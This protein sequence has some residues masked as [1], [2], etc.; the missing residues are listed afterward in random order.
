MLARTGSDKIVTSVSRRFAF[1]ARNRWFLGTVVAPTLLSAGYFGLIASDVYVSEARFV[2]RSAGQKSVQMPSIS[3]LLQSSGTSDTKD[4]TNEVLD[5]IKSR[6]ALE[7]LQRGVHIR[8]RYGS[9]QADV[10]S[11]YPGL[12]RVDAFENLYRYYLRMIDARVDNDS[13]V[14]VLITYGFTPNDARDINRQL[15]A[16]SETL[17]NTLNLRSEQRAIAEA[18]ARVVAAQERVRAARSALGAYRDSAA[19]ID[20]AKQASGVL[21]AASKLGADQAALR[22]QLAQMRQVTPRNPAIPSLAARVAAMDAQIGAQQGQAVGGPG[23]IAGKVGK[24]EALQLEQE[25]ATQAL[26]AAST[27]L[28][29]AHTD[30]QKQHFYLE[31]VVEP[32]LPDY[33]ELPERIKQVLTVAAVTLCLYFIGWMLVVGIL[34]HA[35]ED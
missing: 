12:V 4:Q 26:A 20:P 30:A 18:Q 34:E 28:E 19:V 13:G 9:G 31:R 29:Q 7:G 2:I 1:L 8:A 15:L 21:D 23:A 10:F 6:N 17:V 22:A 27:A 33:P 24:F 3:T 5:Y 25:F 35:P 11:R 32:S 16:Q 14:A